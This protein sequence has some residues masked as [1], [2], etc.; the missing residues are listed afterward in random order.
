MSQSSLCA[1]SV[2]ESNTKVPNTRITPDALLRRVQAYSAALAL[3][4]DG[5]HLIHFLLDAYILLAN[6][7]GPKEH[8]IDINDSLMLPY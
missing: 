1:P 2:G 3:S 6:P 8:L 5:Y 4:L 7:P